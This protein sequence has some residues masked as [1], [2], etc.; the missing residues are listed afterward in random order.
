LLVYTSKRFLEYLSGC[1]TMARHIPHGKTLTLLPLAGIV[2]SILQLPQMIVFSINL[3]ALGV[4]LD[5]INRS[6]SGISVNTGR[7]TN[8]L[9]K[10]T[11][12]NAVELMVNTVQSYFTVGEH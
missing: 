5:W 2:A 8:E 4:L 7:L 3:L 10:G 11:L 9:L 12:G 1:A 6:I